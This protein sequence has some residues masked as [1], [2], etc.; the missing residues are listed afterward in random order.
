MDP[1]WLNE[2][3]LYKQMIELVNIATYNRV[4]ERV[5]V[6]MPENQRAIDWINNKIKYSMTIFKLEGDYRRD[7]YCMHGYL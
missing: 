2:R 5:N 4:L 3:T 1:K 6:M 7:W